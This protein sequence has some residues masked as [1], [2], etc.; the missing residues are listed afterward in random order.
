MAKRGP[1]WRMTLSDG[2]AAVR[3][4]ITTSAALRLT[5]IA[6]AFHRCKPR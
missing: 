6:A 4:A 2:G 3:I 5:V 1:T